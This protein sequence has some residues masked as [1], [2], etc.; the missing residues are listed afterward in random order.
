MINIRRHIE[1]WRQGAKED[2]EVAQQLLNA[3]KIRHG[4]FF[5]HLILGK[6]LKAHVCLYSNDILNYG[7]PF[8]H[9]TKQQNFLLKLKR[10]YNG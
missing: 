4:L 2:F 10:C 8:P 7:D 3:D 1:Q 9:Q 5:L 6:I